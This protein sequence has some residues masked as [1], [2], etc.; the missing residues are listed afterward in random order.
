MSA[1]HATF[2]G[3]DWQPYWIQNSGLFRAMLKLAL[4]TTM[5]SIAKVLLIGI[6]TP[7]NS[8]YYTNNNNWKLYAISSSFS[9]SLKF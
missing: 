7:F 9:H 8:I 1:T 5:L 4:A 6:I 2:C 3:H